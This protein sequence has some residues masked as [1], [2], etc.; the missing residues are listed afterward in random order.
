MSSDVC[1]LQEDGEWKKEEDK[2][3]VWHLHGLSE[4]SPTQLAGE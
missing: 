3:T 2:K 1:W 4:A